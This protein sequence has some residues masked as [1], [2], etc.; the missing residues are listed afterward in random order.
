MM[1]ST[2]IGVPL[3]CPGRL[4]DRARGVFSSSPSPSRDSGPD[5]AVFS[6]TIGVLFDH[7]DIWAGIRYSTAQRQGDGEPCEVGRR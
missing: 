5:P 2:D 6:P 4:A 3:S 1:L 7:D